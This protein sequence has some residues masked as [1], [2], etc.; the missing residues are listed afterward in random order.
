MGTTPG[1]E[2]GGTWA[3]PTVDATHSGSAHHA[4]VTLAASADTLLGLTGQAISL[5]TQAA[6]TILAGPVTGAAAAPDFRVLVAADIPTGV[7]AE[8]LIT[9]TPA[10]SPLVF[11]DVLQNEAGD[12]LLYSD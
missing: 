12:D 10:G 9:D 11:A 8:L 4:A 6:N 7:G 1:G 5:D 2:L 3:S